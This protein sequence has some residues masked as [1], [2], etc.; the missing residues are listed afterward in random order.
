MLLIASL[1]TFLEA[2]NQ[3]KIEVETACLSSQGKNAYG[4]VDQVVF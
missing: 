4:Q 2:A 1:A 3:M